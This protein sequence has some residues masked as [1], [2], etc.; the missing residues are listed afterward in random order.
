LYVIGGRTGGFVGQPSE[1]CE[2]FLMSED[3]WEVIAPILVAVQGAAVRVLESTCC[4]YALGGIVDKSGAQSIDLIQELNLLSLTWRVLELKLPLCRTEIT[5]FV[6]KDTS[7]LYFLL[8]KGLYS[9]RPKEERITLLRSYPHF[10]PCSMQPWYYS[11]G[12]LIRASL[13]LLIDWRLVWL[14]VCKV[15]YALLS[16]QPIS[17]RLL[18]TS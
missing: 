16:A 4:L 18:S 10:L 8:S 12:T 9:F 13:H 5:C 3:R 11:E 6:Y 15:P 1:I 7:Q 14:H 2:R 17:G